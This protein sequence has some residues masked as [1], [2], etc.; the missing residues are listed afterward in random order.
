MT[1]DESGMR[2]LL[3]LLWMG[4][5][6]LIV[7]VLIL[8]AQQLIPLAV[9]I[10]VWFLIDALADGL[11]KLPV[12]GRYISERW[13]IGLALLS[14]VAIGA[15]FVNVIA[16]NVAAVADNAPIYEQNLQNLIHRV[17]DLFQLDDV[18]TVDQ[19][20]ANVDVQ[21]LIVSF[22][23]SVGSFAGNA[24]IILVYV[25]FLLAEERFFDAKIKAMFPDQKQQDNVRKI[26]LQINKDVKSYVWIMTLMS[27]VTGLVSYVAMRIVG[28]DYAEFWAFLIFLLN[29][30]PTI[31]SILG[32][33][34]PTLLALVQFETLG[35]F[36]F[37]LAAIGATQFLIGNVL[38]P[39]LM[40]SRL[41]ISPLV[42]IVS[43]LAWGAIWGVAGMFLC[44][45]ITVILMI[46][47]SYFPKTRPIAILLSAD[48]NIRSRDPQDSAIA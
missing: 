5:V 41:N 34:F 46:V 6:V 1:G 15:L 21:G 9:A 44:M 12:V 22:A 29:F 28:L 35:P 4:T 47:F 31:G 42:V 10:M 14:I 18:P 3:A 2:S 7:A 25:F 33:V 45:P 37:V 27:V 40:G 38:Q 32:T 23:G 11:V 26:L 17:T 19:L 48:G 8:A 20:F 30:I 39:R 24:G 16:D 13:S 36:L 43:L